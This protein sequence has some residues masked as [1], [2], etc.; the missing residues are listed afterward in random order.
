MKNQIIIA[1]LILGVCAVIAAAILS[2]R[3]EDGV[4]TSKSGRLH[5]KQG[6]I[7]IVSTRLVT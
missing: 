6:D 1:S 4:S 3:S 2:S 5:R 7:S